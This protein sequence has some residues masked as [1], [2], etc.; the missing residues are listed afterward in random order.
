[1]KPEAG[2]AGAAGAKSLT[3]AGAA[4]SLAKKNLAARGWKMTQNAK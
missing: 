1:M 4:T 3:V 2:A